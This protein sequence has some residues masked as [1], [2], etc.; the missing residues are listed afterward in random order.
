MVEALGRE[1]MEKQMEKRMGNA[2]ETR[3]IYGL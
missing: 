1:T 2:I 3:T